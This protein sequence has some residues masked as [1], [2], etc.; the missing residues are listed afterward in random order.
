MASAEKLLHEAQFAFHSISFGDTPANKRN[1]AE[2]S[3]ICK[4]IISRYPASMEAD[5]AHAVLRRLGEEAYSSKMLTQHRHITQAAHHKAPTPTPLA[6]RTPTP[7]QQRTFIIHDEIEALDWSGL[8]RTIFRIPKAV[9]WMILIGGFV[10]FGLFGPF[11][12]VP[13]LAFVLLT[14]PFRRALKQEQ[15]ERLNEIVQQINAHVGER[16]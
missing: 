6:I 2:A 14:G 4:K 1:A 11:L 15:R 16:A 7:E 13:L 5:E 8:F 3:S 12:F 9:L 10:L